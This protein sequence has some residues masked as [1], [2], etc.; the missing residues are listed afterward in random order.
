MIGDALVSLPEPIYTKIPTNHL[1]IWKHLTKLKQNF[2]NRWYKEYLNDLNISSKWQ[3]SN[4]DNIKKG[5]LTILKD[6][7]LPPMR[8]MLG[9]ILHIHSR[10]DGEVSTVTVQT[11]T[12]QLKRGI[13]SIAVLPVQEENSRE[14][15]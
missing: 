8:W 2:W 9:R 3:K 12:N 5:V 13:R 15:E 10:R 11:F 4:I 7:N 6:D 14:N 1:S